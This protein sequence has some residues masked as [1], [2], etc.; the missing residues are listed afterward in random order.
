[1][2]IVVSLLVPE[3]EN[4]DKQAP[5]LNPFTAPVDDSEDCVT[6]GMQN[7]YLCPNGIAETHGHYKEN[8]FRGG[9][10]GG[11]EAAAE[12]PLAQETTEIGIA[13]FLY[14]P[15]DLS[16]AS[17]LG[18]PKVPL[19]S[20]LRFTNIDGPAILHT[21]TTCKFPCL[22]PTGAAFPLGDGETSNGT[23]V[24][25]DSGQLGYSVPE[26]S[27]A[28]NELSWS[29]PVTDDKYDPGEIVTYYCRIHPSMRGAFEVSE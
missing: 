1:M 15:G 3:D 9:P 19:G 11:W 16:T 22:G 7:G 20:D 21:I 6:G 25:L 26:I 13:D 2:G 28:K 17:T 4:G 8:G 10:Q 14:L 23:Q 29:T 5:G 12:G 18:V 24:E 27:G